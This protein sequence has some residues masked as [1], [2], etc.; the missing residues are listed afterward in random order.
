MFQSTP[1]VREATMEVDGKISLVLF[2]STPPVREATHMDLF[3][4]PTMQFQSTPP[5]REATDLFN[6]RLWH[7]LVSIHAPREGGDLFI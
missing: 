7:L 2:Q 3:L 6:A 4:P 5:V 1:P